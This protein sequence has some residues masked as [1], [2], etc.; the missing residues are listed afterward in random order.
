MD[1]IRIS[2][3]VSG[4]L[5]IAFSIPALCQV[6]TVY[7]SLAGTVY[8][9]SGAVIPG[10]VVALTGPTANQTMG[11]DSSGSFVFRALTPGTYGVTV[12]KTGF[13]AYKVTGVN[14]NVN[15]VATIHVTLIVGAATQI[16]EVSSPAVVIDTSSTNTT[17]TI[18]DTDYTKLPIGRNISSLFYL[19]TGVANG[20]G[21]G[22]MNPSISG[23]LALRTP[24]WLTASTSLTPAT[25]HLASGARCTELSAR[26]CRCR[27][28]RK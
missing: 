2:V 24:T 16:V 27:L 15:Q 7:G 25:M 23:G 20:I 12:K 5:M 4:L 10:A 3:L 18:T 21:T 8:D 14:V 6:S 22:R 9:S 28:S 26:A 13:K 17:S 11:T 19:A 1:K